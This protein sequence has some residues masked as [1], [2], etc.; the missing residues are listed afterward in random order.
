MAGLGGK[1]GDHWTPGGSRDIPSGDAQRSLAHGHWH[2]NG[3]AAGFCRCSWP[4]AEADLFMVVADEPPWSA[5]AA[6][7]LTNRLARIQTEGLC[8]Q[9]DINS[10]IA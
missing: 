5:S 4:T 8:G 3:L 7:R 10:Q 9:Y 1:L 2:G 6:A